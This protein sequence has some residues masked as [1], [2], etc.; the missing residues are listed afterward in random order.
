MLMRRKTPVKKTRPTSVKIRRWATAFKNG[1]KM[2]KNGMPK[3]I[4]LLSAL[5]IIAGFGLS[6]KN[7][8]EAIPQDP[9]LPFT[10][11]ITTVTEE[12]ESTAQ[13]ETTAPQTETTSEEEEKTTDPET[14][15]AT[16]TIPPHKENQPTVTEEHPTTKQEITT[17]AEHTT[18]P[19]SEKHTTEETATTIQD[20]T[21]SEKREESTTTVII[22]ETDVTE[23][24]A[25][26]EATTKAEPP[27]EGGRDPEEV[28][29]HTLMTDLYNRQITKGELDGDILSFYA[30]YSDSKTDADIKVNINRKG[31]ADKT[32]TG[33][34]VFLVPDGKDYKATLTPGI[35]RISIYYTDNDGNRN[36]AVYNITYI[37][38]KADRNHPTVGD[39][40]PK[41]NTSLDTLPSHISTQNLTITVEALTDD[42][43][44]ITQSSYEGIEIYLDGKKTEEY[45]GAPGSY[46][47]ELHFDRPNTG[48]SEEHLIEIIV[49]DKDGNSRY[50]SYTV[51]YEAYDE[52]E[53]TGTVSMT[54]DATVLGLGILDEFS[55]D[56]IAGKPA[57][58]TVL[59]M[60]ED[61]GYEPVYDGSVNFGFYLRKLKRADT[62]GGGKIPDELTELLGRD[63][64]KLTSPSSRDKLGD[65]DFTTGSGWMFAVNGR[66][67]GKGLSEFYLN[68]DDE[69]SLRYTLAYG[70]DI[71]GYVTPGGGY[72]SLSSY[73]GAWINGEYTP[74]S[75]NYK[76]LKTKDGYD[77]YECEY[78]KK[79]Y[80]K[81]IT[82]D[83]E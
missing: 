17:A 42:M 59:A 19:L 53:K 8:T 18:E 61:F 39:A 9:V 50:M 14:T 21:T 73:C 77:Y 51:T 43:K 30:Y 54:I 5:L 10:Q 71:G 66:F 56:I 3:L 48:D 20:E 78:C 28:I 52:G 76:K 45:T 69:L 2:T 79:E 67:P 6:F 11:E 82:T 26:T 70:K 22:T 81:K 57:A 15:K 4:S 25:V 31:L 29:K 13:T 74:L 72:G 23:T 27:T 65:Y 40:P 62:F 80:R 38:P 37:M 32:Y 12:K 60:L 44:E 47:Y 1:V 58:A 64:I 35:N 68:D 7:M 36:T 41:I 83:G 16:E 24:E 49:W 33:S 75:H 55:Y 34:G 63:G 46:E